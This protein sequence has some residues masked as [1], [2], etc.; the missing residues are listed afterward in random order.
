L[1]PFCEKLKK[2]LSIFDLNIHGLEEKTY[3]YSFEIDDSFFLNY[4]QDIIKAGR[5]QVHIVLVKSTNLLRLNFDIH[6]ELT[7]ECDRSLELYSESF[8]IEESHIFKFG[9]SNQE[10]SD[11]MTMITFGSP[12][13]NVADHIFE[14]IFLSIPVKKIHP[15]FRNKDED[16]E[17]LFYEDKIADQDEQEGKIDPR[18]ADLFKLKNKE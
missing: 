5:A 2:D 9:D 17:A 6:T 3:E 15:D 11:E 13:L 18:W 14:Y 12:K 8:K 7:L 1:H 10:I 16:E 4:E